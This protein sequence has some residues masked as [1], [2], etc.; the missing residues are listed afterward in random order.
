MFQSIAKDETKQCT[1]SPVQVP[2]VVI[3]KL[4]GCVPVPACDINDETGKCASKCANT[5]SPTTFKI[6]C[7][8]LYQNKGYEYVDASCDGSASTDSSCGAMCTMKC[9]PTAP[10]DWSTITAANTCDATTNWTL[11]NTCGN[12]NT[13]AA[14]MIS[15][16]GVSITCD[17][18]KCTPKMITD[19]STASK[20]LPSV[21]QITAKCQPSYKCSLTQST[22][23][24]DFNQS[25]TAICDEFECGVAL[26]SRLF[27][28]TSSGQV[29][30][31]TFQGINTDPL[32]HALI[33]DNI[34]EPEPCPCPG[35]AILCAVGT[36][37]TDPDE[38]TSDQFED[39]PSLQCG[40]EKC[41]QGTTTNDVVQRDLY[42]L[43]EKKYTKVTDAASL[44]ASLCKDV[45]EKPDFSKT[46]DRVDCVIQYTCTTTPWPVRDD[47]DDTTWKTLVETFMDE[48]D[49]TDAP[50][51]DN[52]SE[53]S[54]TTGIFTPATCPAIE[55]M[56]TTYHSRVA[57]CIVYKTNEYTI[58]QDDEFSAMCNPPNRVECIADDGCPATTIEVA[59]VDSDKLNTATGVNFNFVLNGSFFDIVVEA[60]PIGDSITDAKDDSIIWVSIGT[61]VDIDEQNNSKTALSFSSLQITSDVDIFFRFSYNIGPTKFIFYP[62]DSNGTENSTQ[63][64][65]VKYVSTCATITQCPQYQQCQEASIDGDVINHAKCVCTDPTAVFE[66][67]CKPIEPECQIECPVKRGK[68]AEGVC[69]CSTCLLGWTGN[70]CQNCQIWVGIKHEKV[71]QELFDNFFKSDEFFTKVQ[72]YL[73]TT[74]P[75]DITSIT[76]VPTRSAGYNAN[77]QSF[78]LVIGISGTC[79]SN[80]ASKASSA[81]EMLATGPTSVAKSLFNQHFYPS[82][83]SSS[84]L[85][86][87][88]EVIVTSLG[89]YDPFVDCSTETCP[90]ST[91]FQRS[92][93]DI[94]TCID[95]PDYPGCQKASENPDNNSV[96]TTT[97]VLAI[98]IPI[99][100][101]LIIACAIVLL[102]CFCFALEPNST[103][104][105]PR[106]STEP[107]FR[108][109]N[110]NYKGAITGDHLELN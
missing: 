44:D 84:T 80:Q 67:G 12:Y 40:S 25:C 79:E 46:C 98:V 78:V 92:D 58:V 52:C 60:V 2:D 103:N 18:N 97:V 104:P 17:S 11:M 76:N 1:G 102:C 91:W 38:W 73:S 99:V 14:T 74:L 86:T 8:Y 32:Y 105:P 109:K 50:Y 48:Y 16:T 27:V 7:N 30:F 61:V 81:F 3:P 24:S 21:A 96:S 90:D 15:S 42:C 77:T 59:V 49:C 93:A 9:A 72:N 34:E 10:S 108:I 39:C 63:K 13:R 110:G 100:A 6:G 95:N 94:V 106:G 53:Y 4:N 55:D 26:N 5:C 20:Q 47:E 19:L 29:S 66:D 23:D 71:S 101:V 28:T 45:A 89:V 51:S 35:P 75:W 36:L 33:T 83:Y 88:S 69:G 65:P 57:N 70:T 68:G 56:V 87:N 41:V 85:D 31:N 62:T 54:S 22:T 37:S 43:A 107:K 82:L 64:F